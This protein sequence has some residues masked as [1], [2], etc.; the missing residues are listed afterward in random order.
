MVNHRLQQITGAFS[1]ITMSIDSRVAYSDDSQRLFALNTQ[2][3]LIMWQRKDKINPRPPT[4]ITF[5]ASYFGPRV[6]QDGRGKTDI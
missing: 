2:S 4:I 6:S 3:R 5:P 1:E